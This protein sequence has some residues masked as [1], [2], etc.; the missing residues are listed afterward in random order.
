MSINMVV[1]DAITTHVASRGTSSKASDKRAYR[2]A[3]LTVN[4]L[5]PEY[6]PETNFGR[7][8]WENQEIR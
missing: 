7:R 6:K 1:R 4:D 3:G 2:Y 8:S 5:K